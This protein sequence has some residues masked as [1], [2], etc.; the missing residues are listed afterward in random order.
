MGLPPKEAAEL[1][2]KGDT[3][4]IR[5]LE[6]PGT[7]G[8]DDFSRLEAGFKELLLIN[9]GA[10]FYAALLIAADTGAPGV[11]A[12]EA[13]NASERSILL[14]CAALESPS[15]QVRQEAG[16]K[17]VSLVLQAGENRDAAAIFGFL[18]SGSLTN[19]DNRF[20]TT[21]RAACLYRLGRY[22]ETAKLLSANSAAPVPA[23]EWDEPLAFF[24]AWRSSSG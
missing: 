2:R 3:G 13:A 6:L 19:T 7:P 5:H 20:V 1:L 22:E 4:F 21:L 10:P 18:D 9:P 12:S 15:L 8:P 16:R 14:F 11:P 23:G 24:A 17:L